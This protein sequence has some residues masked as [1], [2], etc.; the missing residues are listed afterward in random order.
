MIMWLVLWVS[1][2]VHCAY[3]KGENGSQKKNWLSTDKWK[4]NK[5]EHLKH[6]FYSGNS[7]QIYGHLYCGPRAPGKWVS[8]WTMTPGA[9]Y[10]SSHCFLPGRQAYAQVVFL[11][12]RTK[13]PSWPPSISA[14]I[15]CCGRDISPPI[16]W[17]HLPGRGSL[18]VFRENLP[19]S[20]WGPRT[21]LVDLTVQT[22]SWGFISTRAAHLH[23]VITGQDPFPNAIEDIMASSLS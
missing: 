16:C 23:R 4:I 15:K 8:Y 18:L 21:G 12:Q 13:L 1:Y 22:H 2:R 6:W 17:E 3:L 5:R 11:T 14:V 19:Y 10:K 20:L 7:L 9:I